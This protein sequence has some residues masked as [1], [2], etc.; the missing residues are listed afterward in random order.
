MVTEV[1]NTVEEDDLSQT[2][3]TV[4][5]EAVEEYVAVPILDG[6]VDFLTLTEVVVSGAVFNEETNE[7]P[8]VVW[9]LVPL[10]LEDGATDK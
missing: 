9:K 2:D 3:G 5:D 7:E 6:M 1:A 10:P 8:F 4:R